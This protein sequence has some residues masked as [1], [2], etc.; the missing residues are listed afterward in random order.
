MCETILTRKMVVA[1]QDRAD[2]GLKTTGRGSTVFKLGCYR[3]A[4]KRETHACKLPA[5]AHD[6][7]SIVDA[8]LCS[9]LTIAAFS[10]DFCRP[11]Q[12]QYHDEVIAFLRWRVQN[13]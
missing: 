2:G 8:T 10:T 12:H 3:L 1:R 7:A 11:S 13:P 4:R 5:M 6:A 9:Y